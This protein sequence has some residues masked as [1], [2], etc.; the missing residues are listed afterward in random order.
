MSFNMSVWR[1]LEDIL[2]ILIELEDEDNE[3]IDI[4][5]IRVFK[6]A[7]T[8]IQSRLETR[9]NLIDKKML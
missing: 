7:I 4:S 3:E 2:S 9:Q 8:S 5:K 6:M 1:D